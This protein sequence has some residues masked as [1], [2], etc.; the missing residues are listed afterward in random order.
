[1][2]KQRSI[3]SQPQ[4]K[5]LW[6][7]EANAAPARLARPVAHYIR[8]YRA[9]ESDNTRALS[10][11]E[12]QCLLNMYEWRVRF[13][14]WPHH[15]TPLERIRAQIELLALMVAGAHRFDLNHSLIAD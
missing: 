1:M 10:D 7:R 8:A 3:A 11:E 5:P 6:H 15:I 9:L 14:D 2:L 4:A 13:D 12:L